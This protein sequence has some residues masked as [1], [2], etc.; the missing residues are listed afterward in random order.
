MNIVIRDGMG[1]MDFAQIT[2]M[3]SG[4]RWCPGIGQDK[5]RQAAENSALVVGAFAESEQVGYARVISDKTRF[6][7]LSDV[8]MREDFRGRGV[9]TMMLHHIL[10]HE[11]L[12]DV[13]QWYLKTFD[14]HPLYEKAGFHVIDNPGNWMGLVKE[15]QGPMR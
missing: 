4:A 14:A 3:L 1:N 11:S 2:A 7:Y 12:A 9:A 6:A 10:A 5:V 15:L 13:V 8:F